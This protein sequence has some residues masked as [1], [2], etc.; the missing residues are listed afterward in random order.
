[1]HCCDRSHEG[2]YPGPSEGHGLEVALQRQNVPMRVWGDSS[3]KWLDRFGPRLSV[4][5]ILNVAISRQSIADFPSVWD[6]PL[7]AHA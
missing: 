6:W 3:E 5:S 4:D 2:D 7:N 1:L